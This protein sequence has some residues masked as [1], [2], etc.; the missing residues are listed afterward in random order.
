MYLDNP[1]KKSE[2]VCKRLSALERAVGLRHAKAR[3]SKSKG[4]ARRKS[5][6]K[7]AT[8]LKRTTR[9]ASKIYAA[10]EATTWAQAQKMAGHHVREG[11]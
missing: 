6:S 1:R 5:S 11:Y 4:K 8:G 3:K 9:L 7:K 2:S 10:G